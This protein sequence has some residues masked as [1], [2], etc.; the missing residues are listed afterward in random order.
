MTCLFVGVLIFLGSVLR[1]RLLQQKPK[2]QCCLLFGIYMR[3]KMLRSK[4]NPNLWFV[5]IAFHLYEFCI[6]GGML[7]LQ[8]LLLPT[9]GQYLRIQMP[10]AATIPFQNFLWQHSSNKKSD[11]PCYLNNKNNTNNSVLNTLANMYR[12]GLTGESDGKIRIP[13][14]GAMKGVYHAASDN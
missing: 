2:K 7:Y 11:S 1:F 9:L 6:N 14:K 12:I 10:V 13:G 8:P 5:G 4:P 3:A